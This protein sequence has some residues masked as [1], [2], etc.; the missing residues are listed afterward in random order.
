MPGFHY[1]PVLH[2]RLPN[3]YN[4]YNNGHTNTPPTVCWYGLMSFC[5]NFLCEQRWKEKP[6]Q[7]CII[8]MPCCTLC[9][10]LCM[11][12][13]ELSGMVLSH[14]VS[15]PICTIWTDCLHVPALPERGI[16]KHIQ[17]DN[18]AACVWVQR[19]CFGLNWRLANE[20]G[21]QTAQ[22]PDWMTDGTKPYF[23][24]RPLEVVS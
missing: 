16:N 12:P 15:P 13:L 3:C 2:C 19:L 22:A 8:Y 7:S 6:S 18:L 24:P 14:S 21:A 1:T 17:S 23:S 4:Q 11:Q 9:S 5:T 10:A 20:T